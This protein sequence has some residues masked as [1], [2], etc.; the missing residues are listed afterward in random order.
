MAVS[1][2][3]SAVHVGARIPRLPPCQAFAPELQDKRYFFLFMLLTVWA[4]RIHLL[5][6]E[7]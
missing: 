6:C 3:D 2:E 7:N 5:F 4:E 1:A